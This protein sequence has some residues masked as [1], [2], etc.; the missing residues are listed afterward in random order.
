[1]G[2]YEATLFSLHSHNRKFGELYVKGEEFGKLA[3]GYYTADAMM[4]LAQQYGVEMP[5]TKAVY[6]IL[7]HNA[8]PKQTLNALFTRTMKAE[9]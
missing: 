6:D 5:I 9:F 1:M 8:D 3:E 7:Y 4:R 2:D